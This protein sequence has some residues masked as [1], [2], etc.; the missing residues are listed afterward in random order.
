[1]KGSP[2]Y[3]SNTINNLTKIEINKKILS[4]N[5][6][7]PEKP[8]IST[9]SQVEILKL[10]NYW[11]EL[12][13]KAKK[14][15]INKLTRQKKLLQ[16]LLEIYR[17]KGKVKMR[18]RQSFKNNHL[19]ISHNKSIEGEAVL[20]SNRF[21]THCN[22]LIKKLRLLSILFKRSDLK[23]IKDMGRVCK[24]KIKMKELNNKKRIK[25]ENIN[26]ENTKSF[27]HLVI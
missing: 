3:Y 8:H 7:T 13:K 17:E 6:L 16:S 20:N 15:S 5:Y 19:V 27:L 2:Q 14:P 23:I 22:I 1:M 26:E 21:N 18:N 4:T 11:V 25:R 10:K 9:L 12:S 24:M